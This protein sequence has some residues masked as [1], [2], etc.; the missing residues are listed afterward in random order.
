M[1][2][3]YRIGVCVVDTEL[4][5]IVRV[6]RVHPY[7]LSEVYS[8]E[9]SLV[10]P[11]SV[12]AEGALLLRAELLAYLAGRALVAVLALL[13]GLRYLQSLRVRKRRRKR[14]V[15]LRKVLRN[16]L[17]EPL[18][19]VDRNRKQK[20]VSPAILPYG[21]RKKRPLY[22]YRGV[23]VRKRVELCAYVLHGREAPVKSRHGARERNRSPVR[24]EHRVRS[25]VIAEVRKRNARA[26]T[27]LRQN[28]LR[29]KH[30]HLVLIPC[31]QRERVHEPEQN[32]AHFLRALRLAEER[33]QMKPSTLGA[34]H[35]ERQVVVV[36]DTQNVMGALRRVHVYVHHG[37]EAVVLP[38]YR[39]YADSVRAAQMSPVVCG[40]HCAGHCSY[41]CFLFPLRG[42][43]P[44]SKALEVVYR[45]GRAQSLKRRLEYLQRRLLVF[46]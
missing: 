21:S 7:K 16:T 19:E 35:K 42:E 3:L 26:V 34:E 33:V 41:F 20:V 29:W 4:P 27:V 36:H 22:A 46:H 1:N 28:V 17:A 37:V 45:I 23:H 11:Y 10:P 44:V 38:V 25:P 9:V 31:V 40:R 15:Y 24:R 5:D 12:L 8:R 2:T 6:L 30:L 32:P 39:G 18:L 14:S 13:H 43:L